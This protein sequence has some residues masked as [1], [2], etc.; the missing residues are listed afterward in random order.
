MNIGGNG[1]KKGA[2]LKSATSKYQ[3]WL[4]VSATLHCVYIKIGRPLH[5]TDQSAYQGGKF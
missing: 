2:E 4:H 3:V 1:E 5:F